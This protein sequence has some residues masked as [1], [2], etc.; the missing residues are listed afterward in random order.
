MR[1]S[2]GQSGGGGCGWTPIDSLGCEIYPVPQR[3]GGRQPLARPREG[4]GRLLFVYNVTTLVIMIPVRSSAD[5]IVAVVLVGGLTPMS[6]HRPHHQHPP[7]QSTHHHVLPGLHEG[8]LIEARE[9]QL[10]AIGLLGLRVA[11]AEA[12]ALLG[13][14]GGGHHHDVC[15]PVCVGSVVGGVDVKPVAESIIQESTS[16]NGSARRGFVRV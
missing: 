1:V 3:R 9:L 14:W 15:L 8:R 2:S 13:W 6:N 16:T 5:W 11:A 12:A 4:A 7:T 10:A